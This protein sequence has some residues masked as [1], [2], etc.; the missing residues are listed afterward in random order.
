MSLLSAKKLSIEQLTPS[1]G[2][3]GETVTIFG[4]GFSTTL[5]QDVVKFGEKAA[6]VTAATEWVLTVK[7]PTGAKT[8]AVTVKTSTEGPVTSAQTFTVAGS[9]APTITSLSATLAVP[10]S[11][12]TV[13]GSNFDTHVLADSVVVNRSRPEVESATATAIKLKVPGATG[14]GRVAVSTAF[15]GAVGPDLFIP[16]NGLA[17]TKIS[18]T[19]RFTVG[20]PVAV[21]LSSSEKDALY[22]FDGTAGEEVSAV[23]SED[24]IGGGKVSIWSPT[25]AELTKVSLG[26]SGGIVEP[27]IL[28]ATGTYEVLVEPASAGSV[29]LSSYE[30]KDVTETLTPTAEGAV[31]AVSLPTPGQN[32]RYTVT[33]TAG[34]AVS[35]KTTATAFTGRYRLEWLNSAGTVLASTGSSGNEFWEQYKFATAG[36][37][38]LVVNPEEATTG[39]TTLTA[40]NASDVT[41][42]TMPS[43]GGDAKTVSI[44]VPGQYARITFAGTAGQRISAIVSE[45]TIGNARA[46]IL[47]PE[48]MELSGASLIFG[49][50]G[51][52]IEPVTLLTTGTYTIFIK[53][54]EGQTGKVKLTTYS[55]T[56][57]TG[58]LAPTTEGASKEITLNTPGQ[59]A[60]YTVSVAAGE[61][62]STKTSSTTFS[63]RYRQEWFNAEGTLIESSGFTGNE[64]WAPTT[65]ASAGTYTLVVNPE[66]AVTGSTTLTAY[67]ATPVTGT[68]TPSAEGGVTN[69][70]LAA[71]GQ[72]AKITFS[73]TAGQRISVVELGIDDHQWPL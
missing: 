17:T 57:V 29:K 63:G 5:S 11:A 55:I 33:V 70:T 49:V 16:P 4:T 6:T 19:G 73:G 23:F 56:D 34:E 14:S 8:A 12:V 41:G 25:G 20:T 62:I 7:V 45:S 68:T 47:N 71:P 61:A 42:T 15:G 28:P 59:T 26:G 58:T 10:G 54:F 39:S 50:N 40:Y 65:F 13:N 46:S 32:A 64:F 37:Y 22:V 72:Q 48:G 69:L 38:T 21:T 67:N 43:E 53:P 51:G 2:P 66:G 36:T 1:E 44:N 35:V 9:P 30:V 31:K 3:V 18:A 24:S 27:I 52:M 60:R